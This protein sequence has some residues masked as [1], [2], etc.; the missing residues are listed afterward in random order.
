MLRHDARLGTGEADGK[1]G[2]YE[3]KKLGGGR[4]NGFT[5][6]STGEAVAHHHAGA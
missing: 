4:G 1:G 5:H 3:N 6:G 2:H